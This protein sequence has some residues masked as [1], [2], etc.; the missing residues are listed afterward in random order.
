MNQYRIIT[1]NG[2]MNY[3]K[4]SNVNYTDQITLT[5]GQSLYIQT[6]SSMENLPSERIEVQI[7][8]RLF[9]IKCYP[10]RR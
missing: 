3:E 6:E 1:L 2:I 4:I 7:E 9:K 10:I 8:G 5:G